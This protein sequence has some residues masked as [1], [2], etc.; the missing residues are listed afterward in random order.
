MAENGKVVFDVEQEELERHLTVDD[1]SL[2]LLTAEEYFS[3]SSVPQQVDH[4]ACH[5]RDDT[6]T[7]RV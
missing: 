2:Y 3:N 6:V 4:N 5:F 7:D 1:V